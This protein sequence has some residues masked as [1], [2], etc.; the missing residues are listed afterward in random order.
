MSALTERIYANCCEDC[1]C[2]VWQGRV[3]FKSGMPLMR[4]NG[5]DNTMV[6][7]VIYT[8][9]HGEIPPGKV[10]AVKCGNKR[11]L[12]DKHLV[13]VTRGEARTI[14]AKNGAYKNPTKRRKATMT[15]RAR[16]EISEETVHS[17]RA[18]KDAKSAREQTGVSLPYCYA[19]RAGT[20][21]ASL[22][23]P[24]IGLG[25]RASNDST[26]RRTA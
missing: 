1:D 11:C 22:A 26:S 7:R 23:H 5:R 15:V 16:S 20:A 24:F 10:I 14:A 13:A 6:R 2:L 12:E 21:R 18:A 4:L 9:L 8:E 19:I 17:I 3:S 25:S